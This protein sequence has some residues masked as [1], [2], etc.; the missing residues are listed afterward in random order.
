MISNYNDA[1]ILRIGLD[2]QEPINGTGEI[3]TITLRLVAGGSV[4]STP[5]TIAKANLY[6][7]Y[8]RDFVISALQRK[9]EARHGKVILSDIDEPVIEDDIELIPIEDVPE[10]PNVTVGPYSISGRFADNNDN[11]IANVT[12]TVGDKTTV[13]NEFGYYAVINL[14]EGEYLVTANKANDDSFVFI[15]KTCVVGNNENCNLDFVVDTGNNAIVAK[16]ALYGTVLDRDGRPVKDVTIKAGDNITVTDISGYFAFVGLVAGEYLVIARKG[17]ENLGEQT[18][19]TGGDSNCKVVFNTQI[20][21][22]PPEPEPAIASCQLYVVHDEGLND[23]Q[24]LTISL[25]GLYTV[26]LLGPMYY[27]YDFES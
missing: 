13:T 12:V 18:C 9:V 11:P 8:G 5:L 26:N 4:K 17:A 20:D 21:Q 16:Y 25:D 22:T 7:M 3:V 19:L 23:S 14:V 24:F 2:T 15:E 10:V 6:D 27:G 1:G